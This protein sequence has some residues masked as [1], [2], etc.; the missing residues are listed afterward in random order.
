MFSQLQPAAAVNVMIYSI[1]SDPTNEL[2][3]ST[4]T[5]ASHV[6]FNR[7]EL[8]RKTL[9]RIHRGQVHGKNRKP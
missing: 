6:A 1:T 2:S 8:E 5:L 9:T 4:L 7:S 3:E